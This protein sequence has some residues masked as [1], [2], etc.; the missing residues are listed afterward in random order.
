MMKHIILTM[1]NYKFFK[2]TENI[3]KTGEH[4]KYEEMKKTPFFLSIKA[5][6]GFCLKSM[7]FLVSCSAYFC[8]MHVFMLFKR[9]NL[10]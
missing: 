1:L 2:N 8:I 3:K 9:R 7:S 4:R 10:I 6:Q 5:H